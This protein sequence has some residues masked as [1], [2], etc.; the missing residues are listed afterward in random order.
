MLRDN[1]KVRTETGTEARA[2]IVL[3][4]VQHGGS[5]SLSK[6]LRLTVK[7]QLR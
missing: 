7:H 2:D 1:P 5:S 6:D 4:H 3:L